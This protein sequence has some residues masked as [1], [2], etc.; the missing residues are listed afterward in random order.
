[1]AQHSSP[2]LIGIDGGATGCRVAIA[3]GEPSNVIATATGGPANVSVDLD[4]AI[5]RVRATIDAARNRA[6][7]AESAARQAVVHA[8][9]AGVMSGDM[10][11]RVA[12]ALAL[13]HC[14]VTDDGPTSVAGAL[15]DNDGVVLA[16]GTGTIVTARRG[17]NLRTVG[18]W[19]F[20]LADQAS[21]AWLGRGLMERTLL[22]HDGLE[23]HSA[24]TRAT[25]QLYGGEPARIA[26]FATAAKPHEFAALAPEIVA[27]ASAGDAHGK[28]LMAA[29][30]DYLHGALRALDTAPSDTICLTGG[31]G[32]HYRKYLRAGLRDAVKA[33]LGTALDGALNL[34][35]QRLKTLLAAP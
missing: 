16:V 9:F 1:M 28:A 30:A 23:T 6:G 34:A 24:I 11:A 7:I 13:K 18:G 5:A 12:E 32:P 10:A 22:C 21:G 29:G 27:A 8:G 31:V 17:G 19:G 26:D 25:L 2:L 33:P 4:G 14:R 35:A 15:G 3:L 20:A